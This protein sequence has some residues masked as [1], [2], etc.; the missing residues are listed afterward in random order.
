MNKRDLLLIKELYNI[1]PE[2]RLEFFGYSESSKKITAIKDMYVSGDEYKIRKRKILEVHKPIVNLYYQKVNKWN[3]E[4]N[5]IF[6]RNNYMTLNEYL[7]SRRHFGKIS[8]ER[9]FAVAEASK[10]AKI[11][12]LVYIWI[13]PHKYSE[14]NVYPV[15]WLDIYF[16]FSENVS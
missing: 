9:S 7:V 11:I 16:Q 14:T 6:D 8:A 4:M 2:I 5:E 13:P 15:K 1:L 12:V 3:S 10:K